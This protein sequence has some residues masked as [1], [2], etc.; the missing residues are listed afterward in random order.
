MFIM[1]LGLCCVVKF[2]FLQNILC[3][4]CKP[5]EMKSKLLSS[6]KRKSLNSFG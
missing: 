6:V 3:E 2:P 4:L 1:K 5:D